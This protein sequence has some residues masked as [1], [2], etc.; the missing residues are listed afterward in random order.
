MGKPPAPP[1]PDYSRLIDITQAQLTKNNSMLD[2][3]LRTSNARADAVNTRAQDFFDV[4]MPQATADAALAT[5]Q[6]DRYINQGIPAEN[7]FISRLQGWD[8]ASRRSAQAAKATADVGTAFSAQQA[9]DMKR[10]QA[11]G[12]DPSQMRSGASAN[13]MG[14]AKASAEASASNQAR[15][16]VEA[17]GLQYQGR[18][19]DMYRQI[20]ASASANTGAAVG[21]GGAALNALSGGNNA[22]NTNY[23]TASGILSGG[24]GIAASGYGTANQIYGNQLNAW[25]TQVANS[26]AAVAGGLIGTAIPFMFDSG[27]PVD[28]AL[29]PSAGAIPDDIPAKLSANEYVLP[30]DVVRYHGLKNINKLISDARPSG[31]LPGA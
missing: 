9:N 4:I 28:P 12:I 8:S 27:G 1:A 26:P 15:R 10:L 6:R 25:N 23:R 5:T 18:A 11:F 16:R 20:G 21:T 22:V 29:S 30:E 14:I 3:Y 13:R 2:S 31:A 7:A 17:Q 19:V 24:A